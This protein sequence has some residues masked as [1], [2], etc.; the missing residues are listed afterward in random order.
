MEL[1]EGTQR[2]AAIWDFL[3]TFV[4]ARR[5]FLTIHRRYEK[6]VLKAARDLGVDREELVLP[7]RELWRLFHLRLLEHLRDAR[8]QPL[9]SM[10]SSIFGP[11]G[12]EGLIDAY[13]GHIYHEISILSQ[14]HRSVG[15]FVQYHDP[16]RY[17]DLFRE[18]SGYYPARLR[19]V[20]RLFG[21]AMKRLNE[22]LPK[23]S[24]RG[25][26][27]RSMYLFGESLSRSA[28]GR[29]LEAAYERMYPDQGPIR[30]FYEAARSFHD[31]GFLIEASEALGRAQQLVQ[32]YGGP[33]QLTDQQTA[34]Y[35]D[36]R[37]LMARMVGGAPETLSA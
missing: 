35:E 17:R 11:S 7:P 21:Y 34:A 29:S 20:K 6:R 19:R 33:D 2:G 25:V 16:R 15:R 8:L 1:A 13:V 3:V 32:I 26:I 31:S 28:W 18:V 30:G 36:V 14:E 22:L 10:S 9:R 4:A 37:A 24:E 5:L 12:D 27:V 23:W